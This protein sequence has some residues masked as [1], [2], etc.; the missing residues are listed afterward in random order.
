LTSSRAFC[1]MAAERVTAAFCSSSFAPC[2][3][4]VYLR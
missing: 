4:S 3:S 1:S 2:I